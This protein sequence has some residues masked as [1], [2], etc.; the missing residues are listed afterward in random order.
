M[1][2]INEM[3]NNIR[4]DFSN[5]NKDEYK[6]NQ[7]Y[8]ERF[9]QNVCV[10]NNLIRELYSIGEKYTTFKI[11][12]KDLDS[13]ITLYSLSPKNIIIVYVLKYSTFEYWNKVLEKD[14]KYFIENIDNILGKNFADLFEPIKK[15]YYLKVNGKSIISEEQKSNI[16][17][18]VSNIVKICSKILYNEKHFLPSNQM[19]LGLNEF[20]E[21]W[22][23]DV[24]K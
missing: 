12:K 4:N 19:R 5:A 24:N 2:D 17:R 8:I 9:N 21:K 16:L 1:N 18:I 6:V 13:Y 20:I 15:I 23:I 22:N 10:L 11:T 14:E 3:L 7:K